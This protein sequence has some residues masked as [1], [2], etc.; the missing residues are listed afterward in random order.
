MGD[1][2][3]EGGRDGGHARRGGEDGRPARWDYSVHWL[4]CKVRD[5]YRNVVAEP[6][7]RELLDI[8]R[9]IPNLDE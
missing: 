9:R 4:E 2:R 6:T 5:L 8:V 7:P 1:A 3:I